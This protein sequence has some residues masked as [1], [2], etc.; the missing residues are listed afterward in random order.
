M[1]IKLI[2]IAIYGYVAQNNRP[3]TDKL[4]SDW[5]KGMGF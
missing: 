5:L 3:Q 4:V 2:L 1:N